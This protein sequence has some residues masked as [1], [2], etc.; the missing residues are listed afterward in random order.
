MED[1][2]ENHKSFDYTNPDDWSEDYPECGGSRQ[3]PINIDIQD[4][5]MMENKS[6]PLG[7]SGYDT[8]PLSMTITN[9]GHSGI[10]YI[11]NA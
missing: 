2:H 7:G 8:Q 1:S 3:S 5:K 6:Q 11:H 4:V 10:Y 9:N